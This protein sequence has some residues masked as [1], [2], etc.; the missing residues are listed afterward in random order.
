[1][2]RSCLAHWDHT[3]A[4]RRMLSDKPFDK[5]SSVCSR[6]MGYCGNFFAAK[7][8]HETQA[9]FHGC[10]TR[11]Q[12]NHKHKFQY[13]LTTVPYFDTQLTSPKQRYAIDFLSWPSR[14]WLNCA[15]YTKAACNFESCSSGASFS[16]NRDALIPPRR[17][18]ALCCAVVTKITI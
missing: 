1:M 12:N 8:T 2:L 11:K 7:R 14:V 3:P 4:S 15:K 10:N 6:I 16:S 17:P 13:E 9:S 5:D 18:K